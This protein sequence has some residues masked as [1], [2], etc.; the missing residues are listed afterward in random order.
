MSGEGAQTPTNS[1]AD[2][3]APRIYIK[4]PPELRTMSAG[5]RSTFVEALYAALMTEMDPDG[6]KQAAARE[7]QAESSPTEEPLED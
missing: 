7:R 6:S 4:P 3:A 1:N 2:D 5:Q